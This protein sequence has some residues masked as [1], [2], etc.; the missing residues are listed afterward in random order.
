MQDSAH[1]EYSLPRVEL[2][3]GERERK[4]N[5]QGGLVAEMTMVEV[6]QVACCVSQTQ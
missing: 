6:L 3:D 5:E 4:E 1:N 2:A